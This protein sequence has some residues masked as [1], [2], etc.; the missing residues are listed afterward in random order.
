VGP[1]GLTGPAIAAAAGA[2]VLRNQVEVDE[3]LASLGF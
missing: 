3:L 2:E 1:V